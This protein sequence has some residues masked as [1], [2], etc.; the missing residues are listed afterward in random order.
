MEAL[1]RYYNTLEVAE[2]F[3]VCE[4]TIRRWIRQ[5]ALAAIDLG[6]RYAIRPQDL[7]DFER[8][9]LQVVRVTVPKIKAGR[10]GRR[11]GK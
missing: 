11:E 8:R 1:E 5:G 4:I 2:H 6:T 3:G 7:E 9:R 10:G